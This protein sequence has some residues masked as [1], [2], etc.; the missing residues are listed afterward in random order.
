LPGASGGFREAGLASVG[1]PGGRNPDKN[2]PAIKVYSS[3]KFHHDWSGGS[4]F[5]KE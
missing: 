2:L 5:Y 3:A 4:N 1:D